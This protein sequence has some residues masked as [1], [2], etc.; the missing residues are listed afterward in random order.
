[1]ASLSDVIIGAPSGATVRPRGRFAPSP[2][3]R[4][5]LGN[6]Y[7]AL[8][9]YLSVKSRGGEW[10]LRIEDNDP[11]RS[12]REYADR[13][14]DDLHWLGMEWDEGPYY[15]SER[16][17]IY[18]EYFSRLESMRMLYPCNC[19]RAELRAP[20]ASDLHSPYSGKCR[21]ASLLTALPAVPANIRVRTDSA[22]GDDGIICFDDE[23]RGRQK[24]NVAEEFGDFVVRRRDGAWAYQFAVTIDDSLMN[25]TEVVRGDDLLTS[26][27]PQLYLMRMLGLRAPDRFIHL[28]LLRNDS[29]QRLSKR[30]GS[31]S[32]EQLRLR[33][34]PQ[35]VIAMI[36]RGAGLDTEIAL[37]FLSI[38]A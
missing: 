2:S 38:K 6:I 37:S 15:Q 12:K 30:D 36:C 13:I 22:S 27:A 25:I 14:M 9:S 20:H 11:Q 7:A 3:G 5:H 18:T 19:T 31:L 34:T 4:M 23:I 32:M 28:P 1:M 33:H 21:P 8:M 29:G 17:G 24:I 26:T 16:D 35:D 10:I